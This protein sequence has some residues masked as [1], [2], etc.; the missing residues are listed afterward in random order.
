MWAT[1]PVRVAAFCAALISVSALAA[2]APQ[3]KA[4]PEGGDAKPVPSVAQATAAD[5]PLP[6]DPEALF[7]HAMDVLDS[8]PERAAM[9][10]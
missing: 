4:Q 3:A 9:A 8:D 7:Q 1:Q 10:L 5:A 6:E 2:C